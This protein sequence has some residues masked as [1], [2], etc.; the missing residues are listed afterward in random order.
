IEHC[1]T[2]RFCG[3]IVRPGL[4]CVPL[5]FSRVRQQAR[6]ISGEKQIDSAIVVVISRNS[7]HPASNGVH[8]ELSADFSK[9][10]IAVVPKNQSC[11][12][13]G[14][15]RRAQRTVRDDEIGVAIVVIINPGERWSRE[16]RRAGK[17]VLYECE[18]AFAGVSPQ[19]N[20]IGKSNREVN[21]A[22]VIVIGGSATYGHGG[23]I[24]S[25][26]LGGVL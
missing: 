6:C 26:S 15:T 3:Y 1:Y 7:R 24:E 4:L 18:C 5:P 9:C 2:D 12:H 17:R 8:P 16:A 19:L 11:R 14:S 20:V 22:V 13:C 25:R 10:A 21:V 23:R